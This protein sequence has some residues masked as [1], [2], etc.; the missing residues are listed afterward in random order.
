[1]PVQPASMVFTA[2]EPMRRHPAPDAPSVLPGLNPNHPKARMKQ[3]IST[4]EISWPMMALR[5]SVAI[6]FADARTN[7]QRDRQGGQAADRVDDARS[8]KVR[9]ALAESEIGAELREPAAAP[10]PVGEQRIGE[11]A[12]EY[13][14]HGEGEELPAFRA[15]ARDDGQGR[16]HEHH[17]E[18]EDDHHAHVIG[19]T[20]EEHAALAEEA[21]RFSE[22]RER[23]FAGQ[24]LQ[25]SE[26]AVARGAAHLDRKADEPVGEEAAPIHEEIHH[27]GVVRVLHAAEPCLHHRETGLHEHHEEAANQR[28]GEVDADLVLADLVGD[29]GQA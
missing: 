9:I 8:R 3:P 5:R 22:Q 15:R 28:P 20:G 12:H 26:I 18:Q 7:D 17:L 1:M 2:T 4:A 27:V 19:V 13:G 24:W 6:E 29:V 11:R 14:R 21:P 23:V 10:C 16:I 25:A